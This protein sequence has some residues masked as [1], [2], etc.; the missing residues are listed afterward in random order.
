MNLLFAYPIIMPVSSGGDEISI[1]AVCATLIVVN[2]I[3]LF[4]FIIAK[5]H[6][7]AIN[8]KKEKYERNDSLGDRE[9]FFLASIFGIVID[10]IAIFIGLVYWVS[11]LL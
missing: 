2:A 7:Y 8:A 10:V 11:T 6:N 5:I 9:Y 1:K 4:A 3:W